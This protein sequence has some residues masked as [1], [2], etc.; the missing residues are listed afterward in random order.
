MVV[1]IQ[2]SHPSTAGTLRY[3][4]E[5]IGRG[6]ARVLGV[7]IGVDGFYYTAYRAPDY[8]PALMT[9]Y[10]QNSQDCGNFLWLNAY[11]NFKLKKARFF[12]TYTHANGRLFGGN[13]YFAVPH[14]PLNPR[15]FQVG[16]SVDFAN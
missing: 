13:N 1:K 5:K 7:Q 14:Y 10:R 3:N 2:K 15:R 11:A 4:D 16:V 6:V 12:I 9:F 8:Q